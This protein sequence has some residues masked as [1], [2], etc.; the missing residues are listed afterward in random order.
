MHEGRGET[1]RF[2]HCRSPERKLTSQPPS[3]APDPL[4][5]QPPADLHTMAVQHQ[6]VLHR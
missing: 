6:H 1:S 3:R 2:G 5:S 4:R